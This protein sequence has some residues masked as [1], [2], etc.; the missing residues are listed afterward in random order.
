MCSA[1]LSASNASVKILAVCS[2]LEVVT[3]LI[4]LYGAINFAKEGNPL[5]IWPV[6][7]S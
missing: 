7:E 1:C 5:K 2:F 6:L 4:N 3:E